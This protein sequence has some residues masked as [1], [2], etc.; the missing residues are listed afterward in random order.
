[1]V[2]PKDKHA[3][4][5]RPTH[6]GL[7]AFYSNLDRWHG[8]PLNTVSARFKPPVSAAEMAVIRGAIRICLTLY[9][10]ISRFFQMPAQNLS[11]IAG[12]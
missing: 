9:E 3:E 4:K 5:I 11:N 1:M 8:L 12:Q 10:A 6:Y 7:P 2:P